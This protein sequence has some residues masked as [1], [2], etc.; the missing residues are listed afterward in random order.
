MLDNYKKEPDKYLYKL[1]DDKI[2][3]YKKV[4][5]IFL[6]AMILLKISPIQSKLFIRFIGFKYSN[7]NQSAWLFIRCSGS[8]N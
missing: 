4:E 3:T 2:E 8:G 1:R 7:C 6:I 5:F